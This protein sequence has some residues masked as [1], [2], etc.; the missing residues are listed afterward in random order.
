VGT[1]RRRLAKLIRDDR[2]APRRCTRRRARVALKYM[3]N[4]RFVVLGNPTQID[5]NVF[6]GQ[7]GI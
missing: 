1:D 2:Q 5:K 6:T 3:R 4:I 7:P